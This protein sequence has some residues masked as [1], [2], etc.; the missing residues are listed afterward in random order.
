MPEKYTRP[1]LGQAAHG[2]QSCNAIYARRAVMTGQGHWVASLVLLVAI[3]PIVVM[4]LSGL[5]ADRKYRLESHS[6]RCREHDNRLVRCTVVRDAS[7]GDPVGI[8]SCN[9]YG[10][11]GTA[12]CAHT[13][14]PLFARRSLSAA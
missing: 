12:D 1:S 6:V 8:Q 13:C 9:G 2:L 14:L 7:T 5:A 3:S 4:W 11:T 10:E